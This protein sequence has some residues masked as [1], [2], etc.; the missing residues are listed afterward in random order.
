MTKPRPLHLQARI[1]EIAQD[2]SKLF[3]S[4]HARERMDERGINTLDAV[5]VLRAGFIE[6]ASIC[7]GKCKGEWNCKM[8]LNVRGSREAGVVSAVV[9]DNHIRIITVEWEDLA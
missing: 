7:A 5:R 4:K 9:N 1:R 6:D 2:S 3:F 8:T